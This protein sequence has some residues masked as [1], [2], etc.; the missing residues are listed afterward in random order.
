M[1]A[2]L[3]QNLIQKNHKLIFYSSFGV[4]SLFY[5][6][7]G[8]SIV[9]PD[10]Y[11]YL[12]YLKYN[13]D[14]PF[15]NWILFLDYFRPF[16]LEY[17]L[18]AVRFFQIILLFVSMYF[19]ERTIK[20]VSSISFLPFVFIFPYFFIDFFRFEN[21]IIAYPFL[22][23]S[24]FF[25]VRASIKFSIS[26]AIAS[27]ISFGIAFAFWKGSLILL[28][29]IFFFFPFTIILFPIL[30]IFLFFKPSFLG[31]T[32]SYFLGSSDRALESSALG[33]LLPLVLF[34]PALASGSVFL[35]PMLFMVLLALLKYKFITFAVIFAS[36]CLSVLI[37]KEPVFNWVFVI[38]LVCVP[39]SFIGVGL[40]TLDTTQIDFVQRSID[41]SI[42]NDANF[43]T[44]WSF[45]YYSDYLGYPSKYN[46]G[47]YSPL[48]IN[49]F[50]KGFVLTQ[51]PCDKIVFDDNYTRLCDYR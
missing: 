44:D 5:L 2:I 45:G 1:D 17:G 32:F 11:L 43:Y 19:L 24:L 20:L 12:A 42:A 51:L 7:F 25:I 4:L 39:I 31:E 37:Q 14:L 18:F 41:Y 30:I 13:I 9:D 29:V 10:S 26:S 3:L 23:I 49:G 50:P 6:F 27:L 16:F 46:G 22:F 15:S 33:A 28:P 36:L 8:K 40:A 21:E 47:Y 48:D 35:Y 34:L 38:A